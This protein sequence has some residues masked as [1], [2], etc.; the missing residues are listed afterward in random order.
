M[1]VR[2]EKDGVVTHQRHHHDQHFQLVIHP[3]ENRA[4]YQSQ[5]AAV[6]EV[7]G[8]EDM[9]DEYS[10]PLLTNAEGRMKTGGHHQAHWST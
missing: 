1:G 9:S 3:Q 5:N 7:L 10:G 4:G 6:Y 2:V 8:Q